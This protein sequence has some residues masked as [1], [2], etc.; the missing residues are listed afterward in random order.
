MYK[1][2][3]LYDWVS[4]IRITLI[5]FFFFFKVEVMRAEFDAF[6]LNQLQ[7]KTFMQV[8]SALLVVGVCKQVHHSKNVVNVALKRPSSTCIYKNTVNYFASAT[9]LLLILVP[10]G[11]RAPLCVTLNSICSIL[12]IVTFDVHVCY[13]FFLSN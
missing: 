12:Y 1:H 10:H 7:Q 2:K 6:D 8:L 3:L 9:L 11:F 13:A 4:W 5:S